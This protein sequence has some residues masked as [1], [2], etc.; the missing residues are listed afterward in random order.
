MDASRATFT[1]EG[2]MFIVTHPSQSTT[3]VPGAKGYRV[4]RKTGTLTLW[5][6][7]YKTV[8]A[9]PQ[10]AWTAITQTPDTCQDQQAQ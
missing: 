3:Q 1:Q 4:D 7:H 9:Y 10:G 6:R 2:T 8:A 5:G